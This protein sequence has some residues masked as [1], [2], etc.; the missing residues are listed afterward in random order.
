VPTVNVRDALR[1][2]RGNRRRSLDGLGALLRLPSVSSQGPHAA[3]VQ[4]CANWLVEYL[5]RIG[6]Q[7]VRLLKGERHP[8]VY[9][10]WLGAARAPT[11]L[12]YGHYDVQPTEPS[13]AWRS[14]PFEPT[15]DGNSLRARGAS[16]DKGQLFA[17]VA[18]LEAYLHGTGR[19][20][21]NIRILLDGEEE[22]GSPS[23]ARLANATGRGLL[24]ADAA[25]VSDTRMLG[26]SRP[27]MTYSLR[28]SLSYVLDV[29]GP[30]RDLHAGSFG[31]AVHNPL[32]AVCEIVAGMHDTNRRVAIGGFYDRVL[33]LSTAERA[34][35]AR[36]GPSDAAFRREATVSEDWGERGYT[37][38]ERSTSRPALTLNG[39]AGGTS[40][41]APRTIVPA[42]ARA[43]LSFR[44]VPQQEPAEIDRLFQQH[45]QRVSPTTVQLSVQSGMAVPPVVL[46]R[47][48]PASLAAVRAYRRIFGQ[49]P[50]WLRSG[51]TIPAVGFL[52]RDL[53]IPTVLMGF[54]LP[55]DGAHAPN[56]QMHLPTFFRAID[57]CL[58]FYAE[59]ATRRTNLAR[60]TAND[61]RRALSCR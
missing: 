8:F 9:A 32:Q 21:L 50:V 43:N 58:V 34:E 39:V 27:A 3:D 2:A 51:G 4:R 25:V 49:T 45:L 36:D 15:L 6:L 60:A 28:G 17:H 41:A 54:G 37:L 35:M 31:G 19:L 44:L 7:H 57:T 13:T 61:R 10:D 30:T 14:P 22:I 48:H 26:P 56:E 12:I 29:S 11:L 53:G 46:D 24:A 59:F 55:G 42:T 23:L 33:P 20:P 40:G 38:Y 1:F 5:R 47:S 18:A 52:Q 16:D